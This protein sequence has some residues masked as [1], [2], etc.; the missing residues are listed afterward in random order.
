VMVIARR[1]VSLD[2]SPFP[3]LGHEARDEHHDCRRW[4]VLVRCA[5]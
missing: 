2:E 3:V 4:L 1:V 5:P